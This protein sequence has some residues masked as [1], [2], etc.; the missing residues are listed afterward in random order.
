[1]LN[2]TDDRAVPRE[3]ALALY[4]AARRPKRLVWHPRRDAARQAGGELMAE[5][6]AWMRERDLR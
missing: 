1:M 2:A 6:L 5:T 3:S 4:E